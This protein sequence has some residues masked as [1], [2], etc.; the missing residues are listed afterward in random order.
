[1]ACNSMKSDVPPALEAGAWAVHNAY[2][3]IRAQE[4][5]DAPEAHGRYGALD[6]VA[7]R[8]AWGAHAGSLHE[9]PLESRLW[10]GARTY[11]FNPTP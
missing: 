1:M 6:M 2:A 7:E 11:G 8:P 4:M 5:A 10:I 9:N 3:F